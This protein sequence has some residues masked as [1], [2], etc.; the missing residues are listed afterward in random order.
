MKLT[1][2]RFFTFLGCSIVLGTLV[3]GLNARHFFSTSSEE[4]AALGPEATQG[5]SQVPTYTPIFASA[6]TS[7]INNIVYGDR[8]DALHASQN[9]ELF[10]ALNSITASPYSTT[11]VFPSTTTSSNNSTSSIAATVDETSNTPDYTRLF[12]KF[13]DG[14]CHTENELSQRLQTLENTVQMPISFITHFQDGTY[15]IHVP[16]TTQTELGIN[17]KAAGIALQTAIKTALQND[18]TVALVEADHFY[19]LPSMEIHNLGTTPTRSDQWD[20]LDNSTYS[21]KADTDAWSITEGNPNLYVGVIDT[22]SCN[23][24]ALTNTFVGGYN[25]ITDSS[26]ASDT[27]PTDIRWHGCHVSGTIAAHGVIIGVAPDVKIVPLNVFGNRKGVYDD[28]II[29]AL[30]YGA[31]ESVGNIPVNPYP[32]KVFNISIGSTMPETCG[33]TI[34]NTFNDMANHNISVVVSA[35]ND[36]ATAANYTYANCNHVIAVGATN[37]NGLRASYSNKGSAVTIAAPG[38]CGTECSSD[39]W[40]TIGNNAFADVHGTSMAAPHITGAIALLLS[41]DNLLTVSQIEAILTDPDN[42]Q[43]FGAPNQSIGPGIINVFDM[44]FHLSSISLSL[45]DLNVVSASRF[46]NPLQ[47]CTDPDNEIPLD[48]SIPFS[49]NNFDATLQLTTSAYC[50]NEIVYAEPTLS[51]ADNLVS[52]NYGRNQYTLIPPSGW[53]CTLQSA[54]EVKCE[55]E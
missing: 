29:S 51:E 14:C 49:K 6:Q 32:I 8:R 20:M 19:I 23:N 31:G 44:L 48:A 16:Y 52:V 38:G 27:S 26:D 45:D 7:F 9:M 33:V 35:G 39:I 34:Q 41:E 18:T 43:V 21:V 3:Y 53:Q 37:I 47:Y 28:T 42:L 46:V 50:E 11:P 55:F 4:T 15:V 2:K 30:R 25:F 12:I 40:S 24:N 22:G 54:S 17:S 10:T 36:N 13:N 1:K 5:L